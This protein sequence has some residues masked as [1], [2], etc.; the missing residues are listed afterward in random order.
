MDTP[1]NAAATEHKKG[2]VM[3]K[4]CYDSN[5]KK[6]EFT[7]IKQATPPS[8]QKINKNEPHWCS[9]IRSICVLINHPH[10]E[11]TTTTTTT[12][13]T[14]PTT[15]NTHLQKKNKTPS[16]ELDFLRCVSCWLLCVY[17]FCCVLLF[18]FC[19]VMLLCYVMFVN[20]LIEDTDTTKKH[21]H[22]HT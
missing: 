3:R 13:S 1:Q 12:K 18:V 6:S 7:I 15:T 19:F 10:T 4:C 2:Y 22:T 21:T 16:G 17:T 9:V 14:S 8:T 20:I 11:S 5:Y